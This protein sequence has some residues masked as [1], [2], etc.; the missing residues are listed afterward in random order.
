MSRYQRRSVRRG[1]TLLEVLLVMAILIILASVVTVSYT[2][3]RQNSQSDGARM[4][5]QALEQ[6]CELYNL[7]DGRLPSTLNDLIV[8]PQNVPAGKWRGPYLKD[9]QVPMDPWGQEYQY[10]ATNV[11]GVMRPIISSYG[12]DMGQG[13]GDDISNNPQTQQ[14]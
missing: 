12:P 1:F 14:Q 9:T 6:G 3:I 2:A 11:N 4:N 13:G 5:I 10:Q 8:Q 7:D